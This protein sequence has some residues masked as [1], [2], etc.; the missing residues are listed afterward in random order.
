M[1]DVIY[2]TVDSRGVQSMRKSY[3]GASRGQ[4]VIKLNVEVDPGAFK[5]PVLEQSIVV[6]DWSDNIDMEDVKFEK[7]IIT[8][9]EAEM[10]KQRRLEKMKEILENQGYTVT[11]KTG[12][13]E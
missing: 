7:G 2:L 9:E 11:E 3:Q 4:A 10:V 13:E 6:S 12:D 5:P 1:K 8:Q